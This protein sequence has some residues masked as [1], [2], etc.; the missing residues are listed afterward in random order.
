[1]SGLQIATRYATFTVNDRMTAA[2]AAL[3]GH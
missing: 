3:E 2:Y 1:M